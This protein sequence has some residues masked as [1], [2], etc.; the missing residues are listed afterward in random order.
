[1]IYQLHLCS[2]DCCWCVCLLQTLMC[3]P[4]GATACVTRAPGC[5]H[6]W[7]TRATA[8]AAPLQDQASSHTM[9]L[10]CLAAEAEAAAASWVTAVAAA[11]TLQTCWQ[12]ALLRAL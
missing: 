5:C 4:A 6:L 2:A 1:M 7:C 11:D 8:A 10:A 9:I 12:P 3:S